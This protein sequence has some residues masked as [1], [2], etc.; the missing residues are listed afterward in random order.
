MIKTN[1]AG[2]G[3]ENVVEQPSSDKYTSMV[4]VHTLYI[5]VFKSNISSQAMAADPFCYEKE[6][7]RIEVI[8]YF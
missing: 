1:D 4:K 2:C 6:A 8:F 3:G 5:R 7:C